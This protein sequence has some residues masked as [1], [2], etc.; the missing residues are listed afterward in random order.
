MENEVPFAQ[1]RDHIYQMYQRTLRELPPG[2]KLDDQR[3]G[4]GQ[5]IAP[6]S[7]EP[8]ER[9]QQSYHDSRDLIGPDKVNTAELTEQVVEIWRGFGWR[10]EERDDG[11]VAWTPDDYK[12]RVVNGVRLVSIE[13]QSPCH[14]Q[15]DEDL[16]VDNA[17]VITAD[18]IQ[19]D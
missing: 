17:H 1:L 3:Y 6:C 14:W 9:N 2:F 16:G 18:S 10:T 19:Y 4:A 8:R 11:H 15:K 7:L 5:R 13:A 12:I